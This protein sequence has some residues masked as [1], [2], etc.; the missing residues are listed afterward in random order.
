MFNLKNRYFKPFFIKKSTK[1]PLRK[2]VFLLCSNKITFK[3]KL[4]R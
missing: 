3:D 1:T 2:A 4:P